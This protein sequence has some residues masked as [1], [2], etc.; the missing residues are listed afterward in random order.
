MFQKWFDTV[1]FQ[2]TKKSHNFQSNV[3]NLQKENISI[4][5]DLDVL[6]ML[7]I[8]CFQI[9]MLFLN[10]VLYFQINVM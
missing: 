3:V 8:Y 10:L 9:K 7:A 2:V 6:K 1:F 4:E 5:L